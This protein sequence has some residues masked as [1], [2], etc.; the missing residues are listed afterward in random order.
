MPPST[1][2]IALESQ[3]QVRRCTATYY[4]MFHRPHLVRLVADEGDN[5]AVEVEEKHEQVETELDER[6]LCSVSPTCQCLC[7]SHSL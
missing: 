4:R 2:R 7:L 3:P 1:H 6:F 5:H